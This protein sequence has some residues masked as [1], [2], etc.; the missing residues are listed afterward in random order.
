MRINLAKLTAN[1]ERQVIMAKQKIAVLFGGVSSEH[2][3]SLI[4]AYSVLTNIPADKYDVICVG[5]T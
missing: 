4:S 1:R 5:I 2:E 3:I